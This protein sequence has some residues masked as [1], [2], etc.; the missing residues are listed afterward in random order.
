MDKKVWSLSS[1]AVVGAEPER[2]MAWWFHP[3]RK[4]ELQRRITGGGATDFVFTESTTDGVR[5]RLFSFTDLRGWG[6]NHR[7]ETGLFLDGTA[8]R[9][10]G[11]FIVPVSDVNDMKPPLGRRITLHCVGQLEFVPQGSGS[12]EV[13]VEHCHK[14]SGGNRVMRQVIRR[15][16]RG[17]QD[18]LFNELIADCKTALDVG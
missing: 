6:H 11:R 2:V 17:K 7:V 18:R 14:L 3:D 9:C 4:L 1:S 16:D 10:G 13:C 5:V 15:A 8:A 12:T